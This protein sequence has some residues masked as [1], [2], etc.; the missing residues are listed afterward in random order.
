[1]AKG[2]NLFE[3]RPSQLLHRLQIT[4]RTAWRRGWRKAGVQW[5]AC[6][7]MLYKQLLNT[8]KAS[9]LRYPVN[10]IMFSWQFCIHMLC[11]QCLCWSKSSFLIKEQAGLISWDSATCLV[12][13]QS[14]L[15]KYLRFSTRDSPS[16]RHNELK[17][18]VVSVICVHSYVLGS[19]WESL[20]LLSLLCSLFSC[21]SACT[22]SGEEFP[23]ALGSSTSKVCCWTTNV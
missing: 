16:F 8:L 20:Q 17:Q 14:E 6:G 2:G 9:Q 18:V 15:S 4:E 7:S 12:H 19:V 3:W 13:F 5:R 10:W 11:T 23:L 1:M 21:M 22:S